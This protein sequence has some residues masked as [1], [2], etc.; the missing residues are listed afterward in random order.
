MKNLYLLIA[1]FILAACGPSE[2][3]AAS[4]PEP[5]NVF[6]GTYIGDVLGFETSVSITGSSIVIDS[7]VPCEIEDPY[8]TPSAYTCVYDD[9]SEES[10]AIKVEGDTLT[11]SPVDFPMEVVFER[12]SE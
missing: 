2:E 1:L 12:V 10:G 8:S 3:E 6:E 7:E 9:G 5:V 4:E 11:L